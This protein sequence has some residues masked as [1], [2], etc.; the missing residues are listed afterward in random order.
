MERPPPPDMRDQKQKAPPLG[1]IQTG[2]S[3]EEQF[4]EYLQ[5]KAQKNLQSLDMSIS[6]NILVKRMMKVAEES[7][8]QDSPFKVK[9]LVKERVAVG[10][11]IAITRGINRKDGGSNSAHRQTHQPQYPPAMVIQQQPNYASLHN[12]VTEAGDS[13]KSPKASYL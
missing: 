7:Q 2:K 3:G 4:Y 13:F 9:S 6:N 10:G 5:R 12:T 11:G 1:L 8:Q